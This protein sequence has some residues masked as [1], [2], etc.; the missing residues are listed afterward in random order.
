MTTNL[1]TT[2]TTSFSPILGVQA[3]KRATETAQLNNLIETWNNRFEPENQKNSA[4]EL[5][6]YLEKRKRSDSVRS[7]GEVSQ[8][9]DQYLTDRKSRFKFL[10]AKGGNVHIGIDSEWEYDGENECNKI[11][12]YQYCLLTP[13]GNEYK[14]VDYPKSTAKEDRFEFN[15]YL[16][17]ILNR[18]KRHGWIDE[19]PANTFVYCH[20]MRA[21]LASF[22]AYWNI[23]GSKKHD[24]AMATVSNARGDYG[25]DLRSIGASQYKPKEVTFTGNNKRPEKT[26]IHL[27]DTLFLS[28]GRTS[29]D[30]IGEAI[31]IPKV[32]I[33]KGYSIERMSELLRDDQGTYELY[34]ITDAEI[35]VK[36]GRF[37]EEFA[38]N[39]LNEVIAP[40]SNI[41]GKRKARNR[42]KY[43]PNT[44][45]NLSVALF[46]NV[47]AD[48]Y[49]K[50]EKAEIKPNL[51]LN[52][53]F[54]MEEVITYKWDDKSKRSVP[55]S[56]LVLS[57]ER[58]RNEA[59]ARRC[60]FGGRNED[61]VFGPSPK[62]VIS[63][64]DLV[65]AY[66][67]GLVDILPVDYRRAFSSTN[68]KDYLGHV[69]GFAYVRFRFK[70]GTRFPS[71]PVRTETYGLYYPMEGETYCTAPEIAV[72]FN[73]GCEIEILY[74]DIIPWVEGAEPI[75]EPFTKVIRKLRKAHKG[76]FKEAIS[77]DVGNT[78]YGKIGQQVGFQRN[79]FDT[80]TG[81]S[82]PST[83]SPVTN[84][85]FASHV[86]GFIRGVLSELLAN[87][88]DA[89]VYSA[90]TDGMLTDLEDG[91]QM[92]INEYHLDGETYPSV[93]SRFRDLCRKFGDE[94]MLAL[95]HQV[96]QVIAMKT[97]G[98]LTAEM[99][100]N[101]GSRPDLVELRKKPV[102]AKAG[103]KPPRDC[104][105]E[106]QWMAD[107][108]LNREPS[109]RI[110]NNSLVSERDMYLHELD[111]VEITRDK[112]L[113]LEFDF[114]RKPVNPRM[115]EVLN[116]KDGKVMEHLA[117]D[118]VPWLNSDEGQ[119][120]RSTFDAWRKG[121]APKKPKDETGEAEQ[122]KP[123]EYKRIDARCLKTMDD[124]HDWT[125]FYKIKAVMTVKGQNYENNSSEGIFKRHFLTALT[126]DAWGLSRIGSDGKRI[127][128]A[129][130]AE[131]FTDAGYPITKKD[132][133]NSKGRKLYE[134]MLPA[135]PKL[136]PMLM[137]VK[138]QFPDMQVEKFFVED[139]YAEV[140]KLM[141][142]ERSKLA[143]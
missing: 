76:T 30:V 139:E 93:T 32:E 90:T 19:Y 129:A 84:S 88:G 5:K 107:L 78:L 77:K 58:D 61:Y 96:K 56:L 99:L 59:T 10:K 104:K 54:G 22:A 112:F 113:N 37:A 81:L 79:K 17:Q 68:I 109:Q 2:D 62:G 9:L 16:F 85:Y 3:T 69:M 7:G 114:K 49:E 66:T 72:A 55:K 98:Q 130:I 103:V 53:V 131:M 29:L 100:P 23:K 75:F 50:R 132:V 115:M 120:A 140:L 73:M 46:K 63:D 36:Y 40:E 28:P 83:S 39:E 33:P 117:F 27:K 67:T 13:D 134:N 89:T 41:N 101:D 45:G 142:A 34:A 143:L 11:L 26:S 92:I 35:A 57:G 141:E 97:R 6:A 119:L 102:T 51:A 1:D 52:K 47:Y 12:S 138:D 82:R 108:F 4:D 38:L 135:A 87:V 71:L 44:L 91:S 65:G 80:K 105:D 127:T 125:D 31:G 128:Y 43:L 86:T 94:D 60:F 122:A 20:F 110:S 70:E 133:E 14:G 111:M 18:A 124:W 8:E 126:N 48:L 116:P 21:D 95:K 15:N 137:W 64:W 42:L 136:V 106:N 25:L 24:A 123:K 118:T 74:G 121:K